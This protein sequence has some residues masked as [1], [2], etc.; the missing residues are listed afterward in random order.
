MIILGEILKDTYVTNAITSTNAGEL[1]N[2]GKSSTID[3]FKIA[4]E[5]KKIN[6]RALVEIDDV[7]QD[8]STITLRDSNILNN[9]TGVSF[10]FIHDSDVFNG[11]LDGEDVIVG[12]SNTLTTQQTLERLR[13]SINNVNDFANNINFSITAKE[14]SDNKILLTQNVSGIAG[15]KEN[16]S[17]VNSNINVSNFFLFEHS[18]GLLRFNLDEL[19]TNHVFNLEESAFNNKSNYRVYIKL[20]DVGNLHTKPRDFTLKLKALKNDFIEGLGKDT[21]YFSD[22]GISNFVD[23]S[24]SVEWHV[25]S[26][27]S[28]TDCVKLS[29]GQ[30]FESTFNFVDGEEDLYFD[31]TDYFAEYLT[32]DVESQS[33]V[34][35]FDYSNLFNENTYFTKRF[36][37]KDTRNKID[38]PR[39][40]VKLKDDLINEATHSD[41]NRFIA[42]QEEFFIFNKVTNNRLKDFSDDIELIINSEE[43]ET[44]E[45]GPILGTDVYSYKGNKLTGI[46]QFVVNDNIVTLANDFIK[47]KIVSNG[48][49]DLKFVYRHTNDPVIIVNEEVKTFQMPVT[50]SLD[51]VQ[52][53]RAIINMPEKDLYANDSI[54]NI[55]VDFIDTKRQYDA[56]NVQ[57]D[58]ESEDVGDVFY[59]IVCVDENKTLIDSIPIDWDGN[60]QTP[61]TKEDMKLKHLGNSYVLKLY[62][63]SAFKN[64][65]I[66]LEFEYVDIVSGIKKHVTCNSILR[67]I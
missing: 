62:C 6:A 56:K 66:K 32:E 61:F 29:T 38:Y 14:I 12:L 43:D 27:V 1:S 37:S 30:V 18:A 60:N 17:Q 21:I 52:H 22:L 57:I 51:N 53:I 64:K 42:N 67:F 65:R 19:K 11:S 8:G 63:A 16:S 48:K 7:P 45:F 13:D 33:F 31:I 15:Q 23:I 44:L 20:K 3:L 28:D 2:V 46:K 26:F 49:V 41:K 58:L 59:N 50:E 4:R 35:G 10:K 36:A 39:I 47:Q 40:E 54:Q 5:N 9:E 55:K 24:E 34:I 25:N